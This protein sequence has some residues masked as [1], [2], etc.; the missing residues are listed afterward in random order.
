MTSI[1][2][3]SFKRHDRVEFSEAYLKRT[4]DKPV[5]GTL[6]GVWQQPDGPPI[7]QVKWESGGTEV[8]SSRDLVHVKEMK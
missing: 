4:G 2:T 5:V 3:S 8:M 6:L 7:V 1:E